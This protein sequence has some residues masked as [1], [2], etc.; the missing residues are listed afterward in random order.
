MDVAETRKAKAWKT[1]ILG[2]SAVIGVA[3]VWYA[4]RF[5]LFP[6]LIFVVL[7]WAGDKVLKPAKPLSLSIN[8]QMADVLVLAVVASVGALAVLVVA[9]ATAIG[10]PTSRVVVC[11]AASLVV[12]LAVFESRR[13]ATEIREY[14]DHRGAGLHHIGGDEPGLAHGGHQDIGPAS[15]AAKSVKNHATR[16]Q[17]RRHR[18]APSNQAA[19]HTLPVLIIS[20]RARVWK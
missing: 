6:V 16:E 20:A 2:L 8:L 7:V 15:F 5:S 9:A 1:V 3:T 19:R 10:S 11:V 13:L 14:V 18:H 17:N 12:V 4:E